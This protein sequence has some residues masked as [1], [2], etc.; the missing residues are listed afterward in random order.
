[1][2]QRFYDHDTVQTYQDD[3]FLPEKWKR[4]HSN[5][6]FNRFLENRKLTSPYLDASLRNLS[7]HRL[8]SASKFWNCQGGQY[9]GESEKIN[10]TRNKLYADCSTRISKNVVGS[11]SHS[12]DKSSLENLHE[13][14]GPS[15]FLLAS[16]PQKLMAKSCR[17]SQQ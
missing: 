6:T 16:G 9:R 8:S 2:G 10:M 17:P 3:I 15:N 11:I 1:M 12:S 14:A 5:N 4:K 7:A 13:A